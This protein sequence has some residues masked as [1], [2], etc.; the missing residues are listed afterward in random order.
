MVR[1]VYSFAAMRFIEANVVL[2]F[3]YNSYTD[4]EGCETIRR[5][6][7]GYHVFKSF[8]VIERRLHLNL[9]CRDF[10]MQSDV[11]MCTQ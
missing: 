1:F 6:R 9:A 2:T 11:W 3:N 10:E 7:N 5:I 4:S 8:D